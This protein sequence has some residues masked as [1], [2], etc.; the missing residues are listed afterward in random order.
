MAGN[1]GAE[2]GR[3]GDRLLEPAAEQITRFGLHTMAALGSASMQ[4][5]LQRIVDIANHKLDH[6]PIM[7]GS[8]IIYVP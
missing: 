2:T 3:R 7:I 4:F 1:R 6:D 8:S 5:V